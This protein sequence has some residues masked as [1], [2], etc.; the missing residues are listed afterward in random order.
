MLVVDR[1]VYQHLR[2][3][4]SQLYGEDELP[5]IL[6]RIDLLAGRYGVGACP[7]QPCGRVQWDQR[8]AVL[9]TYGDMVR[10]AFL[11]L[12]L[13]RRLCGHRLPAGG[14]GPR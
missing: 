14:S 1:T 5:R 7:D 4:L 8:D 11:S 12:Q 9:I 13:G 10:A 2:T 6:N 3:H